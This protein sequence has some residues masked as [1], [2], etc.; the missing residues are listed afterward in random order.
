MRNSDAAELDALIAPELIF[1]SYLGHFVSKQE[2]LAIHQSG[3]LKFTKLTPL[4]R[5]IQTNEEFSIV[6]I[7]MHIFGS[8]EGTTIDQYYRFT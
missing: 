1:T 7:K 6:S 8:Y 4:E 3:K 5:H 2:D